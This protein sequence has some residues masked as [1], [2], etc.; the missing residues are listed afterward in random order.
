M[1]PAPL[2]P[3]SAAPQLE[4]V[5]VVEPEVAATKSLLQAGQSPRVRHERAHS[6]TELMGDDKNVWFVEF[7]AP[8]CGHC[9]NLE[10]TW[11]DRL[12]T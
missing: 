1:Q 7:Y 12:V 2:R 4:Y 11:N 9:K 3:L 5:V 8:W 6:D 10:P